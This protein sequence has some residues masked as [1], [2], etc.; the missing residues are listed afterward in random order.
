MWRLVVQ[1][2]TQNS[3]SV[4][5]YIPF[6]KSLMP[7]LSSI[8]KSS[9]FSKTPTGTNFRAMFLSGLRRKECSMAIPRTLRYKFFAL[10]NA[11]SF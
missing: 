8:P 3:A 2:K 4:K 5:E 9:P 10:L 11:K 1:P 6:Q 7:F